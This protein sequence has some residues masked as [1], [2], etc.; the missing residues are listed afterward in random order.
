M[1]CSTNSQG[2]AATRWLCFSGCSPG[3][4]SEPVAAWLETRSVAWLVSGIPIH[5]PDDDKFGALVEATKALRSLVDRT[6]RRPASVSLES[7]DPWFSAWLDIVREV[8]AVLGGIESIPRGTG[9]LAILGVALS[10]LREALSVFGT[11]GGPTAGRLHV[12]T[13]TMV[14]LA[15]GEVRAMQESIGLD[16][17]LEPAE[18]TVGTISEVELRVTNSSAVPLRSLHV[19]TRPPVGTGELPYLADGENAS[20]PS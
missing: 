18:V 16:I 2:P 19:G 11:E 4:P 14:E 1:R 3:R 20:I 13:R 5:L 17:G 10:R 12:F 8:A 9:R 7:D 15:E 6:A